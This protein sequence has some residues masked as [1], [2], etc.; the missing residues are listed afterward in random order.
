MELPGLTPLAD[1]R[2][3]LTGNRKTLY[4]DPATDTWTAGRNLAYSRRYHAAVPLPDGRVLLIGGADTLRV[5]DFDPETNRESSVTALDSL[6][7][8]PAAAVLPSGLVLVSGGLDPSNRALATA[9]LIDPI[10][11]T[12]SA[13]AAMIE[14]RFAHELTTLAA[15]DLLVTGGATFTDNGSEVPLPSVERYGQPATPPLRPGGRL[16]P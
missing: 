3:L 1:G 5:T 12:W 9:G 6:R 4:F 10:A 15:G 8:L 7:I 2:A 14:G 13:V 16:S 11:E